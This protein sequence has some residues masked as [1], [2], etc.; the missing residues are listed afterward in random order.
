MTVHELATKLNLSST[1][2]S[3]VLNGKSKRYRISAKTEQLVMET[4]KAYNFRPS[5]LA[6]S[7]RL[8]QT[9]TVGLV[10]P[11]VSNPFFASLAKRLEVELRREGKFMMLCDT[12][13]STSL[14][15]E[16]LKILFSR[17][18]DG[19]IIA[20]SGGETQH[21]VELPEIPIV[22]IDRYFP[23]MEFDFVSS[24]N[25]RGGLLATEYLIKKG[26]PR[27]VCIQ[28]TKDTMPNKE[29]VR[30]YKQAL[31]NAGIRFE[32]GLLLGNEFSIDNGHSAFNEL[33]N[34]EQKP[35]AIFSL[36][37]PITMG[38]LKAAGELKIS[39]PNDISLI[40]F[41]E[42][43]Y[44]DITS[45]PITTISQQIDEMGTRAVE[46][47]MNKMNSR[48]TT[49]ANF[50]DPVLIERDSVLDVR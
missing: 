13:A 1:T 38:V 21:L 44:F 19:L 23:E 10:I 7:L 5:H 45:P 39:I 28:G 8:Q 22:M 35:T 12:L 33:A 9:H 6:R 24:D 15:E 30:G 14:E 18:I 17:Q 2:V 25:Y 26:H 37:N 3:R 4:A 49:Q 47:L 40:S 27:I 48:P 42:Q 31:E 43:P 50:I 29:R 11:D 41:D 32:P 20:P 36:G 34:M 16:T 46:L